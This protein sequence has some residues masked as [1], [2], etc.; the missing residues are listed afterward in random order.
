MINAE[1]VY[2]SQKKNKFSENM[3]QLYSKD[4][5]NIISNKQLDSFA[6][7]KQSV[8]RDQIKTKNKKEKYKIKIN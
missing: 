7:I 8:F 6:N 4:N 3:Y 5:F 1:L 2:N